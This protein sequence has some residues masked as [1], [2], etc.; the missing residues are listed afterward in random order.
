MMLLTTCFLKDVK[1]LVASVEDISNERTSTTSSP[2]VSCSEALEKLGVTYPVEVLRLPKDISE[3]RLKR[4]FEQF[5][6]IYRVLVNFLLF[7]NN[8]F[9]VN[10]IFIFKIST[11]IDERYVPELAA[12]I[13]FTQRKSAI[14]CLEAAS[15]P[16][17]AIEFCASGRRLIVSSPKPFSFS[18]RV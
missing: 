11:F 17:R 3:R 9:L 13:E 16:S 12:S 7:S 6:E 8:F 18:S 10:F 2:S 15:N 4:I 14:S 1:K 5:G